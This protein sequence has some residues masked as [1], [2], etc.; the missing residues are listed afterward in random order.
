MKILKVLL[1]CFAV[2]IAAFLLIAAFLP[3]EYTVSRSISTT[4]PPAIV[5]ANVNDLKAWD[6][7]EPWSNMDPTIE[8]RYSKSAIGEGAS[9]SWTSENSG[10]GTTSITA[11][12]MP[13]RI[14]TRIDFDGGG[15]D[16]EF[17][18]EPEGAGTK[19]TWSMRGD[20]PYPTGRYFGPLMDSMVG[21]AF[22][23]GL[24][25][26]KTQS[27]KDAQ[28]IGGLGKVLG[29]GMHELGKEIGKALEEA[30]VDMGKAVEDALGQ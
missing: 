3:A 18:F 28:S 6:A 9:Y 22:E 21:G 25:R 17:L 20:L 13:N 2:I 5:F 30:G 26:L 11:S 23:D 12:E 8:I 10:H 1:A 19:I 27:E 24:Q 4:A 7:W 14:A 29:Q 16:G 15:G